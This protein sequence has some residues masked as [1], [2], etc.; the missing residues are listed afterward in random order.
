MQ[1]KTFRVKK[2]EK[3]ILTKK[4]ENKMLNSLDVAFLFSEPLVTR[5]HRREDKKY[6]KC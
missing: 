4:V 2:I 1:Q 3:I 5:N 6:N